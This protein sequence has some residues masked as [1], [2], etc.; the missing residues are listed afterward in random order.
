MNSLLLDRNLALE[1]VRVTESGSELFIPDQPGMILNSQR[2]AQLMRGSGNNQRSTPP[3]VVIAPQDQR[4]SNQS[5]T[6]T[7]HTT[8]IT[9]VDPIISMAMA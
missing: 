1:A 8:A 9:N 7:A 6:T 5:N 2:T 4:V 3:N